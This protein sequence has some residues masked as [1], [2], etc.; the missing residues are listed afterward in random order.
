MVDRLVAGPGEAH[1]APILLAS[2]DTV[3][4]FYSNSLFNFE[5]FS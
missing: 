4:K 3:R 1:R 2:G 5:I